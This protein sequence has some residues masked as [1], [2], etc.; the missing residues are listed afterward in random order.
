[1]SATNNETFVYN[2]LEVKLTGRIAIKKQETKSR[3]RRGEIT[4]TETELYE[5]TPVS[6]EDGSWKKWV[7]MNE[8]FV[9]KT[10]IKI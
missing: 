1:M 7:E 6:L 2:G 4:K 3:V 9:I 5:I 8:L 10:T